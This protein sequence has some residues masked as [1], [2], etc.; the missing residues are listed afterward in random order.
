NQL[1]ERRRKSIL[2]SME[3]LIWA[4]IALRPRSDD[5]K[6][7]TSKNK[8]KSKMAANNK[9]HRQRLFLPFFCGW[10]LVFSWVSIIE[11]PKKIFLFVLEATFSELYSV[12][13][14]S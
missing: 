9:N 12:I 3:L 4:K 6:K 11:S 13:R 1:I 8:S 10:D 14:E 2:P 5:T 7:G